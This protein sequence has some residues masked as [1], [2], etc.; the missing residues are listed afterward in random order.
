VSEI[1]GL[2]ERLR[3]ATGPDRRL[4]VEIACLVRGMI[5]SA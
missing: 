4:D 1:D 2:I 5:G 3:K